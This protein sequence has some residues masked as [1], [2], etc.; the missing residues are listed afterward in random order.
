M[1]TKNLITAICIA[2]LAVIGWQFFVNY[3]AEKNH[4]TLNQQTTHTTPATPT[5]P[6]TPPAPSSA[7]STGPVITSIT[8]Q[9]TPAAAYVLAPSATTAPAT[10][11]AI[12]SIGSGVRNDP[13]YAMEIGLDPRGASVDRVALNQYKQSVNSPG[14]YTYEQPLDV[15]GTNYPALATDSIVLNGQTIDLSNV[16]WKLARHTPATAIFQVTVNNPAGKAMAKISKIYQVFDK[17]D[18]RQGYEAHV[19]EQVNNLTDGPLTVSTTV[20]GPVPPLREMESMDDRQILAGYPEDGS[21]DAG[22]WMLSEFVKTPSHD[23]V[24]NEKGKP[25]RW[26]GASSVYFLAIARPEP[27]EKGL[28][29]MPVSH[30]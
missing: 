10:Q 24:E 16:D 20:N 17:N 22:H 25:M 30:A 26:V 23:L 21:I 14:S 29:S 18:R 3:L 13:T 6:A 11:P 7:P 15:G 9:P 19:V 27:A 4:W 1:E 12:V 8:T 28:V 2:M 5:P